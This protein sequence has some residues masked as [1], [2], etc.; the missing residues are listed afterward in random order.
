MLE[1]KVR[2]TEGFNLDQKRSCSIFLTSSCLP[3]G[4]RINATNRSEL[5]NGLLRGEW[6]EQLSYDIA[7]IQ[8]RQ[9]VLEREIPKSGQSDLS[10]KGISTSIPQK[11]RG[12]NLVR[13]AVYG[14]GRT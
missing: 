5:W 7:F 8:F 13:Q 6:R 3:R 4:I 11:K 1:S 14:L 9:D 2:S 10:K 12:V